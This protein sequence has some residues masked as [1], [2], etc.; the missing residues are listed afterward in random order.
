MTD[1]EKED[2]YLQ[3]IKSETNQDFVND[4]GEEAIPLDVQL[5][6]DKLMDLDSK[7]RAGVKSQAKGMVKTSFE[8]GIP[9]EIYDIIS[10]HRKLSW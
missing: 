6:V 7:D 10:N 4:S 2:A 8:E 1:Q 9:K 3:W 5:A